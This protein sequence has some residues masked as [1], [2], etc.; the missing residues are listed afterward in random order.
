[1]GMNKISIFPFWHGVLCLFLF[2]M[3]A[4]S[5]TPN[6][7]EEITTT[8]TKLVTT[9][10]IDN[11]IEAV[12]KFHVGPTPTW[13]LNKEIISKPGECNTGEP[14]IYQTITNTASN[15]P[16]CFG[17]LNAPMTKYIWTDSGNFVFYWYINRDILLYNGG[18]GSPRATGPVY[19]TTAFVLSADGS[20]YDRFEQADRNGV[21]L[22]SPDGTYVATG[23]CV[24]FSGCQYTIFHRESR[25]EECV[26][27]GFG[28]PLH[29]FTGANNCSNLDMEDGIL[30]NFKN[31]IDKEVCEKT[32]ATG[33][34]TEI[35]NP[36]D[37]IVVTRQAEQR[38]VCANLGIILPTPTSKPTTTPKPTFMS[39][40]QCTRTPYPYL[41]E[42]TP[43]PLA[44]LA[45]PSPPILAP[46]PP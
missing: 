9:V 45:Y 42:S 33:G 31:D 20:I 39:R 26:I 30:W 11:N 24:P 2:V 1:M 13:V 3:F 14:V 25:E 36:L 41:V 40:P 12:K 18:S 37:S 6:L 32:I 4:I 19:Q 15:E 43:V 28:Q 10:S 34:Q 23:W 7:G 46:C 16:W 5:C 17:G 8:R 35:I 29:S 21:R 38:I 22:V 44:E 27:N